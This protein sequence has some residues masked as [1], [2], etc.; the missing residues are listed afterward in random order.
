MPDGISRRTNFV[1]FDVD[2]VAGVVAALV[3]GDDVEARREQIDDLALAFVAPLRAEHREIHR[4]MTDD[5]TVDYAR[6]TRTRARD[7]RVNA[8]TIALRR[9][10]VQIDVQSS[11]RVKR[12]NFSFSD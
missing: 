12:K 10:R 2:G 11:V 4:S 5:S 9:A 8:A 6:R 1:P 3:A 7:E